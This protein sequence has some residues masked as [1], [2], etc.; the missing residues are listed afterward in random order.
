MLEARRSDGTRHSDWPIR[1]LFEVRQRLVARHGSGGHPCWR[2]TTRCYEDRITEFDNWEPS[3][4]PLVDYV[5]DDAEEAKPD[6]K[7]IDN[8]EEDL[9]ANNDSN[10]SN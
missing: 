2:L 6:R 8:K 3:E 10:Q 1:G 9:Y 4:V 5:A 7:S